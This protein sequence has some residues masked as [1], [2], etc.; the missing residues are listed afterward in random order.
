MPARFRKALTMAQVNPEGCAPRRKDARPQAF[1]LGLLL[2]FFPMSYLWAAPPA[3][4]VCKFVGVWKYPGGVTTVAPD[5]RAYPKC[6]G[7][8]EQTWTCQ[9]NTYLFSNNGAPPGEFSATLVDSNHMKYS[10][11]VAERVSVGKCGND[12]SRTTKSPSSTPGSVQGLDANLSVSKPK[13]VGTLLSSCRNKK[14]EWLT[15]VRVAK[16]PGCPKSLFFSYVDP[17]T[18]KTSDVYSTP[19]SVQ[20]CGAGPASIRATGKGPD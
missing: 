15:T 4:C 20:T 17:E 2:C 9:G 12:E 8:R 18:G 6:P 11:G 5:G 16:K 10:G 7:C 3:S 1:I 14:H 19:F 13:E